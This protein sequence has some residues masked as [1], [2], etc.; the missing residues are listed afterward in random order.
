MR[1]KYFYRNLPNRKTIV[2]DITT[3]DISSF[4]ICR[5]YSRG[6]LVFSEQI[7]FFP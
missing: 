2:F 1:F 6:L 4:D 7:T 3:E 5:I